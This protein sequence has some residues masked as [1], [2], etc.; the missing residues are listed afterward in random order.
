MDIMKI[1]IMKND[2]SKI[3]K[4]KYDNDQ[5][6]ILYHI[7]LTVI[8][9]LLN[10]DTTYLNILSHQKVYPIYIIIRNIPKEVHQKSNRYIIVFFGYLLILKPILQEKNN[11]KHS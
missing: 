10:S 9:I 6:Q 5:V 2:I 8:L 7:G 3:D 4:T 11:K 1:D